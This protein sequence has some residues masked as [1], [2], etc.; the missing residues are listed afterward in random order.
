MGQ[1]GTEVAREAADVVLADDDFATLVEALVEGRAF[2]RN[3]RRAL[4]LLLGGNLG[5]LAV[6]AAGSAFAPAPAL[7]TR[8]VLMMNLVTDVLPALAVAVQPP[9]HRDLS[10]LAREGTDALES[11]L[12]HEIVHRGVAT[13][14]PALAGFAASLPS[15]AAR[16]QSVAFASLVSTQLAQTVQAGWNEQRLNR[17]MIGAVGVSGAALAAAYLV[18]PFRNF[19]RLSPLGAAGAAWVAAS[20]VGAVVIA[21]GLDGRGRL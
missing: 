20:M 16:A 8:L 15:G 10:G 13:A 12:R 14:L 7:T 11:P 4:A 9:E 2:W 1:G 3:I 18:P 17:D 5:E 19:L 21:S 6:M